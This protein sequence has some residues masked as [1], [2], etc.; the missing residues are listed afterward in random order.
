[1]DN[2]TKSFIGL[3]VMVNDPLYSEYGR[4]KTTFSPLYYFYFISASYI[5]RLFLIKQL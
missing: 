2:T 1:M 5:L 4:R 3:T